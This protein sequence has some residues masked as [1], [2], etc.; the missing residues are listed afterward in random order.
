M[1]VTADDAFWNRDRLANLICRANAS[2]SPGIHPIAS[3]TSRNRPFTPRTPRPAFLRPVFPE[4]PRFGGVDDAD[5]ALTPGA[6]RHRRLLRLQVRAL[7]FANADTICSAVEV[8]SVLG[9]READVR[10]A[11]PGAA[12]PC[13]RA[14]MAPFRLWLDALQAAGV[15]PRWDEDGELQPTAPSPRSRAGRSHAVPRLRPLGGPRRR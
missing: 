3:T 14:M 6:V 4:Q 12:R 13:G 9:I 2:G 5:G 8:A 11:R 15:V 1:K 10:A 7:L